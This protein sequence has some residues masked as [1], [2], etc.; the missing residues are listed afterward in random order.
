MN[1][2]KIALRILWRNKNFSLI[3]IIGFSIALSTVLIIFLFILNEW[4]FDNYHPKANNTYRVVTETRRPNFT[5]IDPAPF[6]LHR[7][8]KENIPG[9]EIV[10]QI[11]F[12]SHNNLYTDEKAFFENGLTFVDSSFFNIFN[13]TFVNGS[14]NNIELPGQALITADLAEKLYG[15]E[16][17]LGKII[18]INNMIT[19]QIAG[20]I[21]SPPVNTHLPYSLLV[22]LDNLS[23]KFV[24][25]NYDNWGS[26]KTGFAT[27]IVKDKITTK[28][29]IE[30]KLLATYYQLS[31]FEKQ[32]I[33]FI[34]E[35]IKEIHLSRTGAYPGT[36]NIPKPIIWTLESIALFILVLT[37]I[38]FV[39]LSTIQAFKRAKE[40]GIKKTL[41]SSRLRLIMQYLLEAAFLIIVA[42]I[43]AVIIV[44]VF[45]PIVNNFIGNSVKLSLYNHI[46]IPFFLL[47]I[48]VSVSLISGIYPA[49]HI[50]KYNPVKALRQKTATRNLRKFSIYKVF[51]IFQFIIAHIFI[52]SV[53]TIRLQLN[54]MQNEPLGFNE[55]N[56]L[57]VHFPETSTHQKINFKNKILQ[58]P[59]VN[60]ATCQVAPPLYGQ[61]Y[62]SNCN[63]VDNDER[64]FAN[65][66]A[67]DEDYAKTYQ[68]KISDGNWF[69]LAQKNDTLKK[70]LVNQNFIRSIGF[71][72]NEAIGEVFTSG[73]QK[74][75]I[76]GI[77]NDFK[78]F[79]LQ[80]KSSPVIFY[81]D[82]SRLYQLGINYKEG[83]E[84][85]LINKI[86][87]AWKEIFQTSAIT[88]EFYQETLSKNYHLESRIIFVLTIF[89]IMA[90]VISLMGFIGL[91]NY[92][93]NQKLP[94]IAIRKTF[95][96][97]TSQITLKQ[98]LQF[99]SLVVTAGIIAWPICYFLLNKWLQMYAYR[100]NLSI[101]MFILVTVIMAAV[102]S[103]TI[104]YQTHKAAKINP[105][106]ILRD[107]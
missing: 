80:R 35:N 21:E 57:L 31:N 70:A 90:I 33:S 19:V 36:Y 2:L 102:A 89:S 50:S 82:D 71:K 41:G 103:I 77:V 7:H 98:L 106:D 44:E 15:K 24:N 22:N 99:L 11:Y 56:N 95:G 94:E 84:K 23:E 83:T 64:I 39:N 93:I 42:E 86:K 43:I 14:P 9:I 26:Q 107:E 97:K 101:L 1:S 85:A 92:I 61:N 47:S 58:L 67:V 81:Y 6:P 88:Y 4:S 25:F 51:L 13:V 10:S 74:F 37:I 12:A 28:N 104:L 32:N 3:N 18:F 48:L 62:T 40:V 54:Y 87:T 38:N 27:Y 34:L 78:N 69:R 5:T 63:R 68:L 105:A 30:Q 91:I 76:T 65:M 16:N 49:F 53:I 29:N 8:I 96:A 72:P 66:K 79:S 45:L 60:Q 100:M 59:E 75:E 20:I 73:K 17:P 46:S 52:I 55:E